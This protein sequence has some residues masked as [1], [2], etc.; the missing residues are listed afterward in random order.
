MIKSSVQLKRSIQLAKFLLIIF[1]LFENNFVFAAPPASPPVISSVSSLQAI[2]LSTIIITGTGFNDTAAND[3]VF[4]GA[5]KA[6]IT[7]ATT[8]SLTVVVPR[9]VGYG[10]IS[11]TNL[12]THLSGYYSQYF[13][14][15]FDNSCVMP[16]S[17]GFKPRVD[18]PV[19]GT[20]SLHSR[21]RH[22]AMGDMDGDGKPEMV[23][24][25]YDTIDAGISAVFVYPN[26][27][28]AGLVKYDVPVICSSSS[29]GTNVRIADLD[30]DGKMDIIVACSG[31]GVISCI[32]N[33]SSGAGVFTFAGKR[34]I[35]PLEGA[36][37]VAIADFDGDGHPDI[38]ATTYSS[39]QV[40]V[41]R[42]RMTTVPPGSFPANFFGGV[43]VYDS[44][45]VGS[46]NGA[47]P[48][49][50]FGADF[51]KDGHID[52]V[53]SNNLDGTISILRNISVS[54]SLI[55]EPH[56]EFFVDGS[57]TEVQAADING[58]GRPEI[59]VADYF[60]QAMS[61]FANNTTTGT[62]NAGSFT[63]FE[64]PT[65]DSSY[66][67]N[68]SD[69][70]GDG[71]ID[72]VF[73][74]GK[75]NSIVVLR[76]THIAGNP[77]S[78]A[79]FTSVARYGTGAVSECQGFCI[80]DMDGDMK[81]DMAVA[82]YG[83]NSVSIFENVTTPLSQP[84][85]GVD[86]ICLHSTATVTSTHCSNAVGFWSATSGNLTVT[87]GIGAADTAAEITAISVGADTIVYAVVNLF[88]T[89]LVK[90][91]IN[92]RPLADTGIITGPS[93]VC[94][95][96]SITLSDLSTGGIWTS[97][98]TLIAQVGAASGV[99]AGRNAGIAII[100]YTMQSTSCGPLSASHLVT[101]NPLPD[102]GNLSGPAGTCVGTAITITAS[103]TGGTW[104]NVNPAVATDAP[105]ANTNVVTG[106]AIGAD[107]LLYVVSSLT[108][109]ND[110]AV[111]ELG[112]IAANIS[113][114]ITG[115]TTVC[116]ND[117]TVL[118][119]S[120]TGG[121]WTTGSP[122]IASVDPV[123]GRV[124]G[125]SAGI[126][127]ISY[128][129]TY[130]CGPVD[131]FINITVKPLSVAGVVTGPTF[132]CI[133]SQI[134][135]S[136]SGA[137]D[138][139]H[140]S[141]SDPAVASVESLS[142][143]A[144]GLSAGVDTIF[145]TVTNSCGISSAYILDTV[146]AIPPVDSITG[147]MAICPGALLT[148][149]S[150]GGGVTGT[151]AASSTTTATV[152]GGV[153]TALN[154]GTAI[155]SYTVLNVCGSFTDTAAV[156]VYPHP[157]VS[158]LSDQ[159]V[160]NG[161]TFN[162]VFSGP[163]AGSVFTWVNSDTSIGLGAAGTNDT[164]LFVATNTSNSA[165]IAT[166]IVTPLANGCI[167][168]N[169]TFSIEVEPTPVLST[170]LVH[171]RCDS[172]AFLYVPATTTAGVTYS[173]TR[174]SVA[175][176]INSAGAGT[177]TINEVLYNNTLL[178]VVV[179][180][181]YTLTVNGCTN[182]QSLTLTVNPRPVLTTSLTP[183]DVCS[184][185]LFSYS[186]ASSITGS[187]I[188]WQRSL[189]AGISNLAASGV[190][191]PDEVLR[192]T[193]IS[194]I[195][196][197]YVFTATAFGCSYSQIV[198]VNVKPRPV[199]SSPLSDTVCSRTPFNY[200]P[201]GA[202]AG[203][204]FVWS[205]PAVIGILPATGAGAGA[206]NDTLINTTSLA[207]VNA[208]YV[209]TLTANGCINTQNVVLTVDPQ[210]SP[211]PIITTKSPDVVCANTLYQNFG[212]SLQP[213]DP[214]T[215]FV[216]TAT[217]ATVFATGSNDQYCLVNFPYPG[218]AVITVTGNVTGYNCIQKDTFAVT[219]SSSY[220]IQPVVLYLNNIQFVCLPS[221]AETY[222]WGYDN[223]QLDSTILTGETSQ[224]YVNTSPDFSKYYWVM[225]TRDGCMQKT[226]YNAPVAIQEING[227]LAAISL[228]PNPSTDRITVELS[229]VH[230]TDVV[231][232][233]YD[234]AGRKITSVAMTGS[235]ATLDVD[236]LAAGV[237]LVGCYRNGIK[238]ATAR[239]VKN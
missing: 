171:T 163:V 88:D 51:D 21:P 155:I 184:H 167:G 118:Y 235:K 128:T 150:T 165:V 27:G 135:L 179:T 1:F 124:T 130:S 228:Y 222:Q 188:T 41:F 131:T 134:T 3:A 206:I 2:P 57:P 45:S 65:V 201:V 204:T 85:T 231:A 199:L 212:T 152:S 79:S 227:Q 44:F 153:V 208:V 200:T 108:C 107:S 214:S 64:I 9:G 138:P 183:P 113:L 28:G 32:R 224:D 223:A 141:T 207:G 215:Q 40:K 191:N 13:V 69:L 229:G 232:G 127:T 31:S 101:V 203:T 14:P 154:P 230:A 100:Y 89:V 39:A 175:G 173:W 126:A 234:M 110:T 139:G 52:L 71:K 143:V 53:T 58:D 181:V 106:V 99:V 114:P 226:Y 125:V 5:D 116:V 115:D 158:P 146:L 92:V 172:V 213:S 7:S 82:N 233:I 96:A 84:V 190:D 195:P 97:S 78:A 43:A 66:G 123:T 111:K 218:N 75:A 180:Y 177:D 198:T 70:D 49:S 16:G 54:G 147:V 22:V 72:I 174:D 194:T 81:P 86:S 15:D 197:S 37:E 225:T 221:D 117:T 42:N 220:S 94:V 62:I 93:S 87:G 104:I 19:T 236:G 105:S 20:T 176:V 137:S 159:A 17:A 156:M 132:M 80:G 170:P 142:G 98:D 182:V 145:F 33:T 26:I 239:F 12:T 151:W 67:L 6:V 102:A 160:C 29:G 73:S 238:M 50:I 35:Y 4:F 217:N 46:Y 133:G 219:V 59:M 56:V 60:A 91:P 34:D 121:T 112:I 122:S 76:N 210:A 68:V 77:V 187:S 162:T 186:P 168:T 202:L 129:V 205:R 189:T 140:W 103:V 178:P 11:V 148:L 144:T 90:F 211:V 83:T 48:A 166:V 149:S 209:Y 164:L 55:F 8:T 169:D 74:R 109:G 95:N 185:T 23:V 136:V 157:I 47:Y 120:A 192:N 61:V 10:L 38:A 193:T 196:V 119:N 36:P 161:G 25:T 63:R 30:G 24:C 18:I 216:W 237:Y